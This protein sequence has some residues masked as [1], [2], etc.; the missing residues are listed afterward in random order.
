MSNLS[1]IAINFAVHNIDTV[2]KDLKS[3]EEAVSRMARTSAAVQKAQGQT[4]AGVAQ[5]AAKQQAA[6]VQQAASSTAAAE[7]AGHQKT[8]ASLREKL[9]DMLYSYNVLT[10]EAK[11]AAKEQ[12]RAHNSAYKSFAKHVD[13]VKQNSTSYAGKFAAQQSKADQSKKDREYSRFSKH[14]DSIKERSATMA[15]QYAERLSKA[16]QRRA[17]ARDSSLLKKENDWSGIGKDVRAQHKDVDAKDTA[18]ARATSQADAARLKKDNDWN[19]IGKD[20]RSHHRLVDGLQ[21]SETKT[22]QVES[23]KRATFVKQQLRDQGKAANDHSK[24]MQQIADHRDRR[25]QNN[26]LRPV[27]NF[28]NDTSA[29]AFRAAGSLAHKGA[30]FA[31]NTI[32][33]AG[34]GFSTDQSVGE[35]LSFEHKAA[36]VANKL[37]GGG[38]AAATKEAM[39]RS[40]ALSAKYGFDRGDIIDAAGTYF[41]KKGPSSMAEYRSGFKDVEFFAKMAKARGAN[42]KD[43]ANTAGLLKTQD[44]TLTTEDIEKILLQSGVQGKAGAIDFPELASSIPAITKTASNYAGSRKDNTIKL[45]G[46]AQVLRGNGSVAE[47]A[48][49]LSNV[50]E[51]LLSHRE[52]MEAYLGHS[53]TD[54]DGHLT[55]GVDEVISKIFEETGGDHTKIMKLESGKGVIGRRAI[56]AFEGR[57]SDEFFKAKHGYE[58]EHK[59]E[60]DSKTMEKNANH[61]GANAVR[62]VFKDATGDGDMAKM[63]AELDKDF[64]NVMSTSAEKF[65]GAVRQ[66][67]EHVGDRLVPTLLK[68]I[69]VL[70][71]LIPALD[72]FLDSLGNFFG[73]APKASADSL[74]PSKVA[75]SLRDEKG[76]VS[77]EAMEAARQQEAELRQNLGKVQGVDDSAGNRFRESES[78]AWA[79]FKDITTG[80]GVMSALGNGNSYTGDELREQNKVRDEHKAEAEKF[81]TALKILTD[82]MAQ[83]AGKMGGPPGQGTPVASLPNSVTNPGHPGRGYGSLGNPAKPP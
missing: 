50:S 69:P 42:L 24:M 19:A 29:S 41:D 55:G 1:D 14:V 49:A 44:P 6:I 70:E 59:G 13:G 72:A 26:I 76:N 61:A 5:R 64:A 23:K 22:T 79:L 32:L 65:E 39:D 74:D 48:T 80:R 73:V 54:R 7:K 34:G 27:G 36:L 77:P 57:T 81:S 33:N 53:I 20:V 21:K 31:A 43:V 68:L 3:I 25:I 63:R 51:D 62:Q 58:D 40:S 18:R 11:K 71:K 67:K 17:T 30:S 75:A 28:L 52:E 12:E 38:T 78:N 60:F 83:A 15:G 37:P 10:H 2:L 16:E 56:R 35:R 82:A 47:G 46:A 66:L 8:S 4:T 45:L 9:K